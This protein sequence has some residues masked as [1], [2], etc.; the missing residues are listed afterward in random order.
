[1]CEWLVSLTILKQIPEPDARMRLSL[2]IS[3]RLQMISEAG[4]KLVPATSDAPAKVMVGESLSLYTPHA[5]LIT[6]S[7][8]RRVMCGRSLSTRHGPRSIMPTSFGL[9]RANECEAEQW[10][11]LYNES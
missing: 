10:T 7:T 6:Q 9:M 1:M 4:F 3:L 5:M 8:H 11:L 2:S